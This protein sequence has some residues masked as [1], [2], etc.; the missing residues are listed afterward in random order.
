MAPTK[1]E[2]SLLITPLVPEA[3]QH[4]NRVLSSLHSLTSF[5]LGL[6]AGILALQSGYGF[7]FYFL[8]TIL[9]SGLFH[10]VLIHRSGGAGAGSF[11]PG[12]TPGEI[13]GV[14]EM[15]EKSKAVHMQLAGKAGP[16]KII[17]KGAWRD[18]WFGGG[19]MSEALSGFVL[20][21]AGVGGVLR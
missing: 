12:S 3:V 4:N 20:G 21:W 11:F 18:V 7:A 2:L 17:R 19:V 5:L 6:S 10:A 16:R 14:I 15:N 9:V 1:Q 8:G 13:E